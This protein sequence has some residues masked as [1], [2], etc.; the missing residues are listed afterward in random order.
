LAGSTICKDIMDILIPATPE[1]GARRLLL[2]SPPIPAAVR[3]STIS[4]RG[5]RPMAGVATVLATTSPVMRSAVPR[6]A[7]S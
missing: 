4:F 2:F 5:W 3:C 1:A 7:A 6:F